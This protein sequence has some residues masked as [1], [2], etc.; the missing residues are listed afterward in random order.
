MTND[1]ELVERFL[2][3]W[4]HHQML[5]DSCR[6]LYDRFQE[7]K[8]TE[9]AFKQIKSDISKVMIIFDGDDPQLKQLWDKWAKRRLI[10]ENDH[11]D[12]CRAVAY[13]WRANPSLSW[14]EVRQISTVERAMNRLEKHQELYIPQIQGLKRKIDEINEIICKLY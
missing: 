12:F 14:E 9:N 13:V 8:T 10:M 2:Q 6:V 3:Y 5:Q 4:R 1:D 11:R 7:D